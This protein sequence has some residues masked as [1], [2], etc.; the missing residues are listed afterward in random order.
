MLA[1]ATAL[2]AALSV[3][4]G[5]PS[6]GAGSVT[7][8]RSAVA[9]RALPALGQSPMLSVSR[10]RLIVSDTDDMKVVDGRVLGTCTA[11]TVAPVTLRVVSI[12]R[13]NCGDPALYGRH[14]L[15]VVYVA[16]PEPGR[17]WGTD[18]LGIRIATVK[19]SAPGGYTLGPLVVGYPDCS[20]CRAQM[21]YGADALWVYAPFTS[22]GAPGELLRISDATGRVT[23]RWVVP[24]MVRAL[25]ATD[26]DG[27][28]IAPGF[29][30]CCGAQSSS[31][32]QR[33]LYHA[34]PRS[35]ALT[36][37][38]DLGRDGASWLVAAGHT[39]WVQARR[40]SPPAPLWR[41]DRSH[42]R[43]VSAGSGAPST[44][45]DF[46]EGPPMVLGTS[47]N[48]IFCVAG[49][50]SD[51]RVI[52]IEPDGGS[53]TSLATIP[54][55]GA[56]ATPSSAVVLGGSYYFVDPQDTVASDTSSAGTAPSGRSPAVLYRVGR[57]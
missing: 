35:R 33:L 15:A 41:I 20:T 56:Y 57:G 47:A 14:A 11:A 42:T 19:R 52:R 34:A 48:G 53:S 6:T 31:I 44:C 49:G 30:S 45:V 25:L 36:P 1:C 10:G 50:R 18:E 55:L 38:L 16:N 54:T 2:L 7:L 29:D 23:H 46:G 22:P 9:S 5:G 40:P 51:Q 27:L 17:A 8:P 32:S 12:T 24:H 4:G 3:G 21:I 13:G 43:R 37:V 26:A 28:W 39:V